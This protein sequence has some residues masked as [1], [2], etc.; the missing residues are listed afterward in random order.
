M[1]PVDPDDPINPDHY[2]T[3][4]SGIECITISEWYSAN[5]GQAIQYLWRHEHRNGIEDLRK[6][7]WFI[8]RE[9][10][11]LEKIAKEYELKEDLRRREQAQL[12]HIKAAGG[13]L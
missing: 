4:P 2:R 11:R 1:K 5:I 6:A 3:H 8:Q 13:P 12:D 10:G 9:I 7:V